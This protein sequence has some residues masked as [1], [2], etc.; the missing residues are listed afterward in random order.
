MRY[1]KCKR[2]VDRNLERLLNLIVQ[3]ESDSKPSNNRCSAAPEVITEIK[4]V[5][6][7]KKKY[8]R[9]RKLA[10]KQTKQRSTS[11]SRVKSPEK[12]PLRESSPKRSTTVTPTAK[13]R[14]RFEQDIEI[15]QKL[16]TIILKRKLWFWYRKTMLSVL[17][18][19]RSNRPPPIRNL[20]IQ[21]SSLFTRQK[22]LDIQN[23]SY[24]ED[25][26]QVLV[27]NDS[28]EN[29]G[30]LELFSSDPDDPIESESDELAKRITIPNNSTGDDE[31]NSTDSFVR[32]EAETGDTSSADAESPK[33]AK[34]MNIGQALIDS[35]RE[36]LSGSPASPNVS[37]SR[38]GMRAFALRRSEPELVKYL[39]QVIPESR[40]KE[41]VGV[42]AKG[43]DVP[44][45]TVPPEVRP[46][47]Q[48]RPE[49]CELVVDVV[50]ELI[51]ENELAT[52]TYE[53]FLKFVNESFQSARSKTAME[54]IEELMHQFRQGLVSKKAMIHD[55]AVDEI[56][57]ASLRTVLN[58]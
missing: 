45:L 12:S 14:Q 48:F 22:R 5:S 27:N 26:T 29:S 47:F 56:M 2:Q 8:D 54:L 11:N 40:F 19:R 17:R 16:R 13:L 20:T 53:S 50:T 3:N 34:T 55:E 37:P 28:I 38:P 42:Q 57:N 25:S 35:L 15:R 46:P 23:D 7:K 10:K 32:L 18:N 44:P 58:L 43:E 21:S 52:F 39:R 4:V 41:M 1:T 6:P 9:P 36:K 51:N 49:Y 30:T 31:E 33:S 24:S